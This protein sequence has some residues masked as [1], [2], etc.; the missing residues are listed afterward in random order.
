MPTGLIRRGAAYSLRRRIPLDL[1]DAYGGRKEIVLALG[2]N[3]FAEAKLRLAHK[4]V[5]LNDEFAARRQQRDADPASLITRT[6][7]EL[8]PFLAKPGNG[9]SYSDAEI[10]RQIEEAERSFRE[11]FEAE[12]ER[13]GRELLRQQLLAVLTVAN[14]RLTDEQLALKDLLQDAKWEVEL[15]EAALASR[16]LAAKAPPVETTAF[17]PGSFKA[18]GTS[19]EKLVVAWTRDRSPEKRTV[20]AHSAVARWFADR[21]KPQAVNVP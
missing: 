10:D 9:T 21:T 18:D 14:D 5:E 8:R 7:A 19:W 4:Q 6:I 11:Q 17:D 3:D 15:A 1:I 20:A 16:P 2:T 13:E 12:Q